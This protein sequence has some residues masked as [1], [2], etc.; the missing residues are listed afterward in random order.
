MRTSRK[1]SSERVV[2]TEY[3]RDR[4]FYKIGKF[5]M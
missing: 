4:Q 3:F 5:R 1:F 2:R